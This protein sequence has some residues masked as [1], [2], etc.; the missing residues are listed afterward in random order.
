[1]F[2]NAETKHEL[3]KL[4]T[5]HKQSILKKIFEEPSISSEVK[6]EL[7]EKV[8]GD[9]KSDIAQNT[10]ETCNALIPTAE[11]KEAVWLAIT[12]VNSTDSI[13]KRSAKMGGFYSW[14]QLDLI[15][16]YFA[17][18][19][20]VLPILY[21]K[22]AFKFI[23]A[24]FHSLLP[25]MEITNEQIVRMLALKLSIPDNNTNFANLIN[26]GLELVMR[27]KSVREFAEK[28]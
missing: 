9:D 20:E 22:Q 15:R 21:E 27:S 11:S 18:Y 13:Y 5:R 12:D 26:E 7:L 23:E 19:F 16:P 14:K 6:F 10:R 4:G 3:F 1:M 28:Q 8:L 24:F 2:R 25:R 17:R